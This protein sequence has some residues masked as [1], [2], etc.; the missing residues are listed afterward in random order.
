[1]V[2]QTEAL[3]DEAAPVNAPNEAV[4]GRQGL[5]T[6]SSAPLQPEDEAEVCLNA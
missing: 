1:M 4:P 2:A 5:G 6:R 3:E